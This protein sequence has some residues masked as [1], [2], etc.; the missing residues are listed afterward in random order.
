MPKP[1]RSRERDRYALQCGRHTTTPT[2]AWRFRRSVIES[3]AAA[4]V[5]HS[6]EPPVCAAWLRRCSR[7]AEERFDAG[8]VDL[9]SVGPHEAGSRRVRGGAKVLLEH[10]W[11]GC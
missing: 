3:N 2:S 5:W 11:G 7:V 9:K 4:Q 6:A 10:R 1:R 8:A